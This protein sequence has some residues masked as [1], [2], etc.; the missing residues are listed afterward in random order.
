M[1]DM[2]SMIVLSQFYRKNY[3]MDKG[4]ESNEMAM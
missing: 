3:D 1:H 2:L 4:K